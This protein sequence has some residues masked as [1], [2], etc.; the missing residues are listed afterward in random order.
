M[1]DCGFRSY[2]PRSSLLHAGSAWKAISFVRC[3]HSSL[4]APH[5]SVRHSSLPMLADIFG[6][7]MGS[8]LVHGVIASHAL[9][10][11]IDM[12]EIGA[13][14]IHQ[15]F[16]LMDVMHGGAATAPQSLAAKVWAGQDVCVPFLRRTV[17]T[18]TVLSVRCSHALI[19]FVRTLASI[20]RG[21]C[22][23]C[24]P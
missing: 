12:S 11:P 4:P 8:V 2:G 22:S 7:K 16:L 1:V 13:E 17:K 5:V 20:M 24:F 23:V 9:I 21:R 19:R 18:G 14:A 10:G 6:P 3:I 15:R